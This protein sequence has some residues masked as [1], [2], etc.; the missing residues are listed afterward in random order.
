MTDYIR[1]LTNPRYEFERKEAE[2]L[3]ND[4]LLNTDVDPHGV[5]RWLSNGSV[6]PED[7]VALAVHLGMAVSV[8]ACNEARTAD[9]TAWIAEY[10]VAQAN[11]SPEQVAEEQAMARAAHGPGVR[12]VNIFTGEGYTT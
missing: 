7:C 1:Q 2:R 9:L 11:R 12:L 10:R 8:E 5:M 3:S 6:P 4:L